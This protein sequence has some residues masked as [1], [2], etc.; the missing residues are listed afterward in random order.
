MPETISNSINSHRYP[1]LYYRFP[2]LL[3]LHHFLVAATTLRVWYVRR[4][5]GKLLKILPAPFR[6]LDAGCGAGDMII[7][8]MPDYR[9]SFFIGIDKIE[10]NVAVCN[11]Y[12]HKRD[13]LNSIFLKA[14]VE[15]YVP[16]KPVDIITCITVLQYV[17]DDI[18]ALN[19][20]YEALIPGGYLVL[21]VPVNYDRVFHWYKWLTT[22]YFHSNEYDFRQGIK[23]H[24][25]FDDVIKRLTSAGFIITSSSYTYGTMGKIAYELY[26]MGLL[27]MQKLPWIPALFFAVLFIC[28]AYPFILLFMLFDFFHK[29]S[30]GNGLL[31][32]ARK[33]N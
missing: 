29:K 31:V 14:N 24:Y 26:S 9:S 25:T 19:N 15:E 33:P 1:E 17:E 23:R 2:F 3:R 20:F 6:F 4:I 12:T 18:K 32:V 30:H 8:Y 27:I 7:P 5:I 13:F 16:D 11:A 28:G 21:Y 10:D 22:K